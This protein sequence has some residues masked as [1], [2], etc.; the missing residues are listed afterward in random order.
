MGDLLGFLTDK[1][2]SIPLGQV[3]IF[4]LLN[5][6]FIL[7]GKYKLGL[8]LSYCF[9]F[10]WGFIFNLK[11]FVN[12]LGATT[13]GMPLYIFFGIMM[14]VLAIIGFFAEEKD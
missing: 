1:E 9:V 6:L 2:F 7:F 10:Y 11:Y 3:V 4:V 5:S 12:I 13:I 8:L 14:L